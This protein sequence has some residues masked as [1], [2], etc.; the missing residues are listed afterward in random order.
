MRRKTVKQLSRII[1]L[2]TVLSLVSG[3]ALNITPND[4]VI[5]EPTT[6]FP[7]KVEPLKLV[8]TVFNVEL[9]QSYSA[10]TTMAVD[11]LDDVTGL[12]YNISRYDLAKTAENRYSATLMLPLG[13]EVKYRY[14]STF[15]IEQPE[16]TATGTTVIYRSAAIGERTEINDIVAGWPEL[17]YE[18][19][20]GKLTGIVSDKTTNDPLPDILVSVAGY[21][22]FTDMTGRFNL[23]NVPTGIHNLVASSIDGSFRTFQQQANVVAGLSTPAVIK[24][25]ALPEVTVTFE[26]T[27]PEE[28]IGA[29]IRLAGNLYQL[30][31]AFTDLTNGVSTIASRMPL[32]S[33]MEDDRYT[34][35]V[36]LHAGNDLRYKYTLGDGFINAERDKDGQLLV[37]RFIVPDRDVTI[38]DEVFTWRQNEAEPINIQISVPDETPAGD[39]ISIQFKQETWLQ[40]IPMWPMGANRWMFLLFSDGSTS[41]SMYYRIC[42]NDQCELAYDEASFSSPIAVGDGKSGANQ[43]TVTAWHLWQA[44]GNLASIDP[45]A[46]TTPRE[47]LSGVEFISQYHPSYINR[48]RTIFPELKQMGISWI[49]FTP[50]WKVTEVASLP[51]LDPDPGKSMLITDLEE[52]VKL[53]KEYGF[54]VGLYPQLSFTTTAADWWASSQ[55]TALWWQQWYVE[56][57]RFLMNY[58]QFAEIFGVDQLIISGAEVAPSLPSALITTAT[59]AGT[60]KNSEKLWT[61][62]IINLKK[63]YQG[64]LLWGLPVDQ[65]EIP[66]Y[67]FYEKLNG[68]YFELQSQ[69]DDYTF[70]DQTTVNEY[71]N[72]TIHNFQDGYDLPVYFGLNAP[73]LSAS[74][75][76]CESADCLISPFDN[77]Y[78]ASDVDLLGQENFYDT[79]EAALLNLEWVKGVCT[80]GFFPIVQLNDFSS[81]VYGK[82]AMDSIWRLNTQSQ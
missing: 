10:E 20:I 25:E 46:V 41:Q 17:G 22:T 7:S 76:A 50:S 36:K 11:V 6:E 18:G 23:D 64:S 69:P 81:S 52:L 63:Y 58:A 80:R 59:N 39:S 77:R 71:L 73:S 34:F 61:D 72:S 1:V 13:G 30:G 43:H 40:P 12:T 75:T 51:Y 14:I 3:C 28:A 48:Y 8:P 15:P 42:R 29:P 35:Q 27:L 55:R 68:F 24:I 78:S 37:R 67:S 62:L 65:G 82:P 4:A 2:L 79:Y 66:N 74:A 16:A 38:Q 57:E 33:R 5:E 26:V 54:S 70:Y 49:I 32:L 45:E 19:E 9:R 60:P 47:Q 31:N 56:Y 21:Q 53:A 44:D